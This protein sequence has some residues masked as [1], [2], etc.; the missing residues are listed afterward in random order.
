[1]GI[2]G[3][4]IGKWKMDG[5]IHGDTEWAFKKVQEW[6]PA[7]LVDGTIVDSHT[8][9]VMHRNHLKCLL[10]REYLTEGREL[11]GRALNKFLEAFLASLTGA[12]SDIV[13]Q[14]LVSEE[15]DRVTE[16]EVQGQAL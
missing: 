9:Q 12:I 11:S 2:T 6:N 14:R 15:K 3:C 1:M 10:R 5:H 16:I 4:L 8:H 7:I 13:E